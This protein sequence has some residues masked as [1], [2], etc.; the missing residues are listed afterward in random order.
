MFLVDCVL[1]ISQRTINLPSGAPWGFAA[2]MG[3]FIVILSS[4]RYKGKKCDPAPSLSRQQ[5]GGHGREGP[6]AGRSFSPRAQVTL[7]PT[8]RGKQ[9]GSGFDL[10]VKR[11]AGG[12]GRT[13]GGGAEAGGLSQGEIQQ[14]RGAGGV[15]V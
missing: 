9:A 13:L 7:R 8:G 1:Q 10:N 4:R 2:Q 5:V 15:S 11:T 12:K 3:Q 14:Q 6:M